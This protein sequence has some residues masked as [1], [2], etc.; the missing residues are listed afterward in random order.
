M[1]NELNEKIKQHDIIKQ[2]ITV[3]IENIKTIFNDR[4]INTLVDSCLSYFPANDNDGFLFYTN[5]TTQDIATTLDGLEGTFTLLANNLETKHNKYLITESLAYTLKYYFATS[6]SKESPFAEFYALSMLLYTI[7]SWLEADLYSP[8]D[9][10]ISDLKN[11]CLNQKH[12]LYERR[13]QLTKKDIYGFVDFSAWEKEKFD[14]S[15]KLIAS[16]DIDSNDNLGFSILSLLVNNVV[17][18]CIGD[19]DIDTKNFL[20]TEHDPEPTNHKKGLDYETECL[21]LFRESG[22]TAM[23]TPKTGD[24]GADIIAQKRG[25]NVV[26]QC[27]NWAGKI[28]TSAIQEISTA[29][30]YYEADLAL[31]ICETEQT[32]QAQEMAQKLGILAIKKEDIPVVEILIIK[33]LTRNTI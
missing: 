4:S 13:R 3:F 24:M 14:Y 21:T 11:D 30:L 33:K 12:I 19:L 20:A 23:E 31:L 17:D 32:R 8:I 9:N 1:N 16:H 15:T 25:F 10:L 28:D 5:D 26:A 6:D 22:W 7:N 29:K 18:S 2:Q 27:K